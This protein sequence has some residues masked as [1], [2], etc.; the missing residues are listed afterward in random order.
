MNEIITRK[1][2]IE[3][4]LKRYFTGKSCPKGHVAKRNVCDRGCVQ[5]AS[6]RRAKLDRTEY[7]L[8]H[9]E[10]KKLATY[11]WREKNRKRS[12]QINSEWKKRNRL[13]LNEYG[14]KYY[15]NN[16]ER[17]KQYERNR[18]AK[19]KGCTG[20]FTLADVDFL[21]RSQKYKCVYCEKSV[22]K[23][24]HIDHIMPLFLGGSNDKKN[25]Q[26]LCPT[27][28]LKKNKKHPI[29]W[30]QENGKLL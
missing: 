12:N 22:K 27:C 29:D 8:T 5:C 13:K 17:E 19:C 10:Q 16:P 1:Q 26:I 2:A 23:T 7:E 14:R 21:I 6:D 18:R 4:G 20:S 24:F 30:A 9:K 15:A 3:L 25:L 11:A 28:N